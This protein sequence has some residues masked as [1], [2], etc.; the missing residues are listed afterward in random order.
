MSD[1]MT[2]TAIP[3]SSLEKIFSDTDIGKIQTSEFSAMRN[4]PINFQIAY[5][6]KDEN[7]LCKHVGVEVISDIPVSL[8]SIKSVP[9]SLMND[10]MTDEPFHELFPDVLIPKK[11][12][13][14]LVDGHGNGVGDYACYEKDDLAPL[15]ASG[16]CN[17]ALWITVNEDGKRLEPG[18][19]PVT[20]RFYHM[21]SKEELGACTVS[22]RLIPALLPKQ[23]T[24][25][26]NWFHCDCLADAYDVPVFSEKF[27]E[28][29]KDQV[30][31]AAKNGMNM[32]LLPAFT[33][34]LDT[35]VGQ[36]R[37]TVQL[38]KI[39]LN[40]DT[41]T[42]DFSEMKRYI[43]ICRKCGI[44]YFEHCHLFSQWGAEHTPKIIAT[45]DG[46]EKQLFGWKTKAAGKKYKAFLDAYLPAVV[47]FFK[48]E[49]LDKKVLFHISD[50]PSLHHLEQ[51][52]RLAAMVKPHLSGQMLGDALSHYA[53]YK[54]GITDLPI[55]FSP[56]VKDFIGKCKHFWCYYTGVEEPMPMS[57]RLINT[58][59][60]Y[61]RALGYQ[62]Y[63]TRAE[64]FLHW[65]YNYYYDKL[66]YGMANPF[67]MP[68]NKL[69]VKAAYSFI[70]YPGLK[71]KTYPSIRQKVFGEAML[72]IRA[73]QLLERL[74]GRQCAKALVEKYFGQVGYDTLPESNEQ[75]LAFRAE[76]NDTICNLVEQKGL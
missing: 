49:G 27:Y 69:G 35:A 17:N 61:N 5:R 8:Y 36:E 33:P 58:P 70:V 67:I 3:I 38:V 71:G 19:Y 9:V 48:E 22:I 66:S 75:L 62:M 28:I 72:D 47:A 31:V 2:L 37:M 43:D 60:R 63:Y 40:G 46:K 23:K 6:M 10:A 18:T 7:E 24:Y 74:G 65:G 14:E 53:F 32:M 41:Y 68:A 50:E 73:L 59:S 45:V 13:P 54:Q 20:F 44:A 51:Y 30:T 34:A 29:F 42:F 76:L 15:Y 1:K 26:T 16:R 25:C 21:E 12:N 39:T 64:G 52:K 56:K 55:I 57:N 11:T 4:E